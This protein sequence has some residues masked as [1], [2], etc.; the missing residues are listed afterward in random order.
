MKTMVKEKKKRITID[1]SDE[2]HD[3]LES[4]EK[5]VGAATKA[6]LIRDALRV[7]E[8]LAHR[9]ASGEKLQ[10]VDKEGKTQDLV[11]LVPQ[12]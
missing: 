3:R 4:L 10:V 12:L 11:I 9:V 6:N 2:F 7:Y 8:Y 1:L 5:F